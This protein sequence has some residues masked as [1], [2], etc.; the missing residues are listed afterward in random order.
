MCQPH[1]VGSGL[2]ATPSDW[3]G[4]HLWLHL[5]GPHR[6]KQAC[7][8]PDHRHRVHPLHIN[9]GSS[10]HGQPEDMWK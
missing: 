4:L 9:S 3:F 7:H 10:D 1:R 2:P 5:H 6:V 8:G